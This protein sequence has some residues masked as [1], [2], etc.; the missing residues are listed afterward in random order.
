MSKPTVS[1]DLYKR[2]KTRYAGVFYRLRADGSRTYAVSFGGKFVAAG[3]TEKEALAK[4]AQLRR[5]KARGEKIVVNGKITFRELAAEWLEIKNSRLRPR[6]RAYYR[7]ALDL[8]LLPR[9][10]SWKV[11]AVDAEAISRLIR[12]LERD[13]LHALDSK[14]PTRALG[15]SSIENYLKPALGI[16][17]LAVRRRLI[18]DNPFGHLTDDDRPKREETSTPHEWTDEEL[19]KLLA[20]CAELAQKPGSRYDYTPLIRLTT[21]LGLRIGEVLGLKWGDFDKDARVLHVERQWLR[22]REYGPTKTKAGTRRIALPTDVREELVVLRLR[23][24]F[25]Q[26]DQP[27]FASRTG[28]PLGHRNV[29]RRGFEPAARS[30]VSTASRSTISAMLRRRA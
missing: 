9:F 6:T 30:P 24:P 18:A 20:A 13:G 10:G 29:T 8:V 14:R 12:D 26:D 2:H 19:D 7:D 4:Q 21:R 3:N 17:K 27:L 5:H 11:S 1:A 15:R 28:T 23:S 25:S 22:T 16:L